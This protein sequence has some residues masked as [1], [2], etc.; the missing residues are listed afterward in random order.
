[1]AGLGLAGVLVAPN[2]RKLWTELRS[3]SSL[4]M[5]F[6][7]EVRR[8]P[9]VISGYAVHA[10]NCALIVIMQVILVQSIMMLDL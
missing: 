7:T 3:M 9:P 6:K 2:A 8:C 5:K 1:M 4:T 10:I